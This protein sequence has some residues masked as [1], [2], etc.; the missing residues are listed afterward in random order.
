MGW[1]Y[2]RVAE[3]AMHAPL[4]GIQLIDSSE[5]RLTT[6]EFLLTGLE[7]VE[8][9]LAGRDCVA[10]GERMILPPHIHPGLHHTAATQRRFPSSARG[11]T[12][13]TRLNVILPGSS[14]GIM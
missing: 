1:R 13:C 6:D 3:D 2:V 11:A 5:P 8:A 9:M 7:H 12:Y 4:A 10:A 14:H